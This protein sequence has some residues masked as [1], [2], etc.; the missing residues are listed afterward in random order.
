MV[1]VALELRACLGLCTRMPCVQCVVLAG[2][3]LLGVLQTGCQL[4]G[5]L[6]LLL[7]LLL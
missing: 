1:R 5:L 7:S 2:L 3:L 6:R 4:A